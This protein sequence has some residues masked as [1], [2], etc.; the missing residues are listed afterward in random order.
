MFPREAATESGIFAHTDP[1]WPNDPTYWEPLFTP[2]SPALACR[3]CAACE[4]MDR[5]RGHLNKVAWWTKKFVEEM[6]ATESAEAQ[7]AG[8]FTMES[9]CSDHDIDSEPLLL[10][11]KAR[12][13]E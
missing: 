1:A 3:S 2:E 9:A 12:L 11:I 13:E 10:A 8:E 6:F 4:R 5:D 7:A